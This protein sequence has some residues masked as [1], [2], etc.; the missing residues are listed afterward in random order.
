[1]LFLMTILKAGVG[2]FCV[3]YHGNLEKNP[4]LLYHFPSFYFYIYF[5][6]QLLVA[7]FWHRNTAITFS[8]V[9]II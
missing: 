6:L 9:D 1:M 8:L 7:K 4:F 2:N 3:F 5:F